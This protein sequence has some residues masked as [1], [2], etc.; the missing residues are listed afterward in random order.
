M[1][2]YP[3]VPARYYT[4][5]GMV[6]VRAIL[7]HMAEGGGTVGYL[8]HPRQNVSCHYVIERSGRIVQMV[9]DT[10]A[11]HSAHVAIDPND[12][13]ADDCG[14]YSDAIARRVL[15]SGWSD[16]NAY[17]LA[18]EVEGFR[19]D[20]PNLAQGHAIEELYHV[21]RAKHP[22]IRGNLGHRDVQDYKSCPG[23]KFPWHRIGG[24][25]MAHNAAG[26]TVMAFEAA[27]GTRSSYVIDIPAQTPF[28]ADA[29]LRERYGRTS[30]AGT[31]PYLGPGLGE[32][33]RCVVLNTG[34]PYEDK[35]ARPTGVFVAWEVGK[36]RGLPEPT[37]CADE[38]AADRERAY[39]AYR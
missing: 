16:I 29:E 23:C 18:V 9:R 24:H 6:E 35:A 12:V 20:G 19:R 32:R 5:G 7:W 39:I 31:V 15:G 21:L 28:Y 10:D 13:D 26:G 25:G 2:D 17:V 3:F 33:S 8:T 34:I 27:K 22:T 1:A 11:S 14:I 30:K 37:D 4:R 38:I 36:P